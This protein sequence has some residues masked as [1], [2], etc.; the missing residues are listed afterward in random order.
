MS[1]LAWS[2]I[3][4]VQLWVHVLTFD[5]ISC[6]S[7]ALHNLF[8]LILYCFLIVFIAL[9]HLTIVS[10]LFLSQVH[11]RSSMPIFS[12][13]LLRGR[14]GLYILIDL[15]LIIMDLKV[16]IVFSQLSCWFIQCISEMQ[17]PSSRSWLT[18][19]ICD[20]IFF[21]TIW[22]DFKIILFTLGILTIVD[23][24]DCLGIAQSSL[25]NTF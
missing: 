1:L 13:V 2:C 15:L 18:T 25:W 8:L 21:L 24:H 20:N 10:L 6:I 3:R 11:W 5:L 19:I 4:I 16:N 7:V 17:L 9:Q 14:V 23:F 22:N 12:V